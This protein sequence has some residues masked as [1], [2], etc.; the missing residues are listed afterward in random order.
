MTARIDLPTSASLPI[1][2]AVVS[3]ALLAAGLMIWFALAAASM[4]PSAGSGWQPV[5]VPA[6]PPLERGVS[7]R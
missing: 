2:A 1:R 3:L 7:P 5:P 4:A 6:P